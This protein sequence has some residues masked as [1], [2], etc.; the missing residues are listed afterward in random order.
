MKWFKGIVELKSNEKLNNIPS[1]DDLLQKKFPL[2]T[3][4]DFLKL[5][6]CFLE[7]FTTNNDETR[8]KKIIKKY[9]RLFIGDIRIDNREELIEFLPCKKTNYSDEEL[10]L[11]LFNQFHE[12]SFEKILG[13]FSFVIIELNPT[14]LF[15][16]RDQLGVKSLFWTK[17]ETK[18]CFA[19]DLFL[20][21]SDFNSSQLNKKYVEE[22]YNANGMIDSKITPYKDVFRIP[23]GNYSSINHRYTS[24]HQYWNLVNKSE[25]I[26]YSSKTEYY[27]HFMDLL[28][29]SIKSR[30]ILDGHNA[31]M[32]SGGLDS[33]SIF[34]ISKQIQKK[35]SD[36]YLDV[37]SGVFDNLKDCDE[38]QYINPV[39]E[40]YNTVP[41][42]ENCDNYGVFEGFP[43]DSDWT[44]EPNVNA[45][46]SLFTSS[47]LKSASSVGATNVLTG[48]GADHVL[49][50]SLGVIPDL[51][52]QGKLV[53]AMN[54][55]YFF[56]K[57]TRE[58]FLHHMLHTMLLPQI[59]KGWLNEILI[60][61]HK[62]PKSESTFPLSFSQIELYHQLLGTKSRL[63]MDR[64]LAPKSNINCKHPFLDRKLIEF[65]F[66][67]PGD[68]CWDSG[69]TK[70]ILKESMKPHLPSIILNRLN[71]TEHLS[72]T[73]LGVRNNWPNLYEVVKKGRITH[74]GFINH[75]D[76]KKKLL[77][78]RQGLEVNDDFWV[79]LTLEIWLYKYEKRGIETQ[80]FHAVN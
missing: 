75:N 61:D 80:S 31:V 24:T 27:D 14:Q 20:L 33:T 43:A 55:T 9:N 69:I 11:E 32:M 21:E 34:A 77:R 48:C 2:N 52:R 3:N 7:V 71:K 5:D 15:L 73:F 64:E 67:I 65:L 38:R 35:H 53:K 63:F 16:V 62:H 47:L 70:V 18:V 39:V 29:N 41:I 56:S 66:Q 17:K 26:N 6:N 58:S 37:I 72:L 50:G 30:L 10:V 36:L 54:Q 22:F 59:G 60:H 45:A 78:W 12:N 51:F 8:S 19:T 4:R 49:G 76:W 42:F 25:T 1:G 74:Y 68:L 79:L 13:D 40:K 46:S 23:S 57:S 28:K 44:F